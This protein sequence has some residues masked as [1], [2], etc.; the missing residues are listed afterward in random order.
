MTKFFLQDRYRERVRSRSDGTEQESQRKRNAFIMLVVAAAVLALMVGN[1]WSKVSNSKSPGEEE[2]AA[3][4]L[5]SSASER[6]ALGYVQAVQRRDFD[7]IFEMTQWMQQRAEHIRLENGPQAAEDAIE[8]FYQQERDG[9]FASVAGPEL[10]EEGIADAHLFP[11]GAVVRIVEV[12]E[13][14]WRPVLSK[15]RPVNMVVMEVKYPPGVDAPT[16]A[17]EKRIDRL[18]AALYLTLESAIIKASICGNA[19]VHPE[20]IVYRHLTP[21]ETLK[22][23]AKDLENT[24]SSGRLLAPRSSDADRMVRRDTH[25]R[26]LGLRSVA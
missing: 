10:T 1:Q 16:A 22:I 12:R 20:S 14:L 7:R 2:P 23:R 19:R 24:E 9:F 13:G 18:R 11:V 5:P 6:A 25:R 3:A 8:T 4:T 26:R 17:G 15:G 21:G